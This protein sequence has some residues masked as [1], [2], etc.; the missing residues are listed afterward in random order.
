M[1]KENSSFYEI[2][3]AIPSFVRTFFKKMDFFRYLILY[4]YGGIY[5]DMDFIPN[6]KI[7]RDIFDN[8]KIHQQDP[9]KFKFEEA[10]RI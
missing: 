4:E 3:T 9:E 6:K 7:P 5:S 8:I 1:K 10:K 2:N